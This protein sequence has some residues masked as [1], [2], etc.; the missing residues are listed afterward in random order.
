[1]TFP[2][3]W[4]A[5]YGRA[6][7]PGNDARVVDSLRLAGGLIPGKT[8]TAEFAVHT[9]NETLNPHNIECTP[10]TSSSGS[11][12]A[13]AL[14]TSQAALGSQTAG[15]I[16]RPASFCGVYGFK[17]SFGFIPR[18]G[19]L[20][21]T[22]S[23]DTVGFFVRNIRD[24]ETVFDVVRV[25]GYDYP[26][27]HAAINDHNRQNKPKDRPWRVAL[28]ATQ[29]WG[30]AEPYAKEALIN[31]A[32]K[33]S[34]MPDIEVATQDLPDIMKT[35]DKVHSTIYDRT[36]AYYF[37]EESKRSELVSPIMSEIIE[38]GK[39][40]TVKQYQQALKEQEV[41]S[42]EM[43]A[44]YSDYDIVISLSTAGSAPKREELEK[45][46]P[47][48]SFSMTHLSVLSVPVFLSPSG[49]PFGAQ[50]VARRYNDR[51]LFRFVEYLLDLGLIPEG[52]N[53]SLY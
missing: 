34:G 50:I 43:D 42:R 52:T 49:M 47:A 39:E 8:V 14:G 41:L 11:A 44:F 33:L 5:L 35:A 29:T 18:T 51:L 26:I 36:L 40:I 27:S 19:M 16:V 13:I 12:V 2:L 22:D 24:I 45:P 48:L 23:L 28:A 9:L 21:T 37:R 46:D 3:R 17:P 1:M 32:D 30:Y 38:R 15:S 25:R 6:L 10:G 53:P 20:K 31:W 7:S 4:E